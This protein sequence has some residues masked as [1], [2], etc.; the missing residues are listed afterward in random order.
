MASPLPALAPRLDYHIHTS[1]S[2]D[3]S[4]PM[5]AMCRAAL[6]LGLAEIGFADHLDLP[7]DRPPPPRLDLHGWWK[8]FDRCRR[9]FEGRLTLRAGLELGE[10][11]R[12][13]A[14]YHPIL[15]GHP[16]D[17]IL[18]SVHFV[19]PAWIFRRESF[20]RG[21]PA[22][23]AGYFA[24][25]ERMLAE[26]DVDIA[27]HV[28]IVK[29]YAFDEQAA[30]DL[31]PHEESIR[32]ALV[33]CVRRGLALEVNTSTL[34]RPVGEPSP[35]QTILRWYSEAGGSDAHHPEHVGAGLATAWGAALRAGL[36]TQA[37]FDRR[38]R[39]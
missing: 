9:L 18:G 35:G 2:D 27:A 28:D 12:H 10:P 36:D 31:R 37:R 30:L 23:I 39:V 19:G 15:R 20:G 3:C 34:R 5:E 1:F 8:E 33:T 25:L 22:L 6:A 4:T 38:R 32:R 7:P 11:H 29:R 16:W 26:A 24:E 21:G 17:F 13:A 14:H